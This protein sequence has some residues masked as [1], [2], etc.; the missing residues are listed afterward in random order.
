M[1]SS[2]GIRTV[3]PS[4]SNSLSFQQSVSEHVLVLGQMVPRLRFRDNEPTSRQSEALLEEAFLYALAYP[5]R[6][7]EIIREAVVEANNLLTD[8]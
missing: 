1:A 4:I 6:F 7:A 2:V 5:D 3:R 8:K